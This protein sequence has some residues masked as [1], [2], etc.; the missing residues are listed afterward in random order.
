MKRFL[1]LTLIGLGLISCSDDIHENEPSIQGTIGEDTHYQ[2]L[3]EDEVSAGIN[4]DSSL[5]LI[6]KDGSAI[7]SLTFP[8][9]DQGAEYELGKNEK[10]QISFSRPDSLT[11]STGTTGEGHVTIESGHD[12]TISGSFYFHAEAV[13]DADEALTFTKGTFYGIPVKEKSLE[14]MNSVSSD[15]DLPGIPESP[16]P[17]TPP[18]TLS[19]DQAIIQS[20][21]AKDAYENARN[22]GVSAEIKKTCLDY[23]A[24]LEEQMGVCGDDPGPIQEILDD[25]DC[26]EPDEG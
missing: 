15:P 16:Q 6:G 8:K 23:Q 12:E 24:A 21:K 9:S 17:P 4:K 20:A 2:A 5:T 11:Y 22:G 26:S 13:D 19:C 1:I 18:D 3:G 14:A 10:T 7:I 25:L